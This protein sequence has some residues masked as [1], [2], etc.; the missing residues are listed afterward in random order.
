VQRDV[1]RE[2]V[3]LLD[4]VEHQV[5]AGRRQPGRLQL[6]Q[7]REGVADVAGP[8]VRERRRDRADLAG[9]QAQGG[10]DVPDRVPH[11]VGVHH[12]HAR[13][14]LAAELGEDRLVHLGAAGGLDVHVDVRELDAQRRG[15][16]LH[17]QA[18]AQRVDRGDAEQVVDE[19][20]GTRAA[21][22]DADAEVADEVDDGGHGE[23][24]RG[25]AERDDRLQLLLQPR[26]DRALEGRVGARVPAGDRVVAPLPED[27]EGVV[28]RLQAEDLRLGEAEVAE[29]QV[30]ARVEPAPQRERLGVGEE[31]GGVAGVPGGAR[32]VVPRGPDHLLRPRDHL[33]GRCEVPLRRRP[34]EG[35]G[36]RVPR[37]V[38]RRRGRRRSRR[39]RPS[40]AGR[41]W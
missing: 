20:A 29:A 40:R 31:A 15:E 28:A 38:A 30:G 11:P 39:P 9:R 22:G 16:P 8:D 5:E 1:P 23:E 41:R 36:S 19:A 33:A 32:G 10:A 4:E 2:A 26:L 27:R 6:G 18:V 21:G 14:P 25:D 37:A 24:V 17:Q 3:E 13:H 7:L 35:A 12:R 34:V